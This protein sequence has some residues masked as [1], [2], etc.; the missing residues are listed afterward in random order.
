MGTRMTGMP[1]S[2]TDTTDEQTFATPNVVGESETTMFFLH[3]GQARLDIFE[4]GAST[5]TRSEMLTWNDGTDGGIIYS[6][7]ESVIG[8]PD[9]AVS[10]VDGGSVISVDDG[11][12]ISGRD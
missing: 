11:S 8:G 10:S 4:C 2:T 9:G 7:D 6:P 3:N 12:V 1:R 5:P